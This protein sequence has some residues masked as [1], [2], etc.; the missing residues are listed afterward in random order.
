MIWGG[1]D[2]RDKKN[3]L[4]L[5]MIITWFAL[6]FLVIALTDWHKDVIGDRAINPHW[7]AE[8]YIWPHGCEKKEYKL[9]D[10]IAS[11]CKV[12]SYY[13]G[14]G[15]NLNFPRRMKGSAE[16]YRVGND[17]IDILCPFDLNNCTVRNIVK[18]T[19]R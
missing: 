2:N 7:S 18:N 4:L 17:A 11:S 13:L 10:D 12:S 9:D 15:A 6:S 8:P 5:G 3:R 14:D 19:Y 1:E 16:Y